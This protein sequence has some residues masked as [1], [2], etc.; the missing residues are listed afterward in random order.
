VARQARDRGHE[1]DPQVYLVTTARQAH[2]QEM[3]GRLRRYLLS[4]SIRVVFL[5]LAI[6]VFSGWLRLVG[7]AAAI[8]LP[9]VAVV[10]ANAGPTG[11]DGQPT[12]V[13][14]D[15]LGIEGPPVPQ[16]GSSGEGTT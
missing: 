1:G 16:I 13:S 2:S 12:F 8:V 4:M 14:P 3:S 5:V 11:S 10:L 9:W 7:I 6:F 15:H